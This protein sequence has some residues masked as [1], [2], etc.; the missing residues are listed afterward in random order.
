MRIQDA[1]SCPVGLENL[2]FSYSL[3]ELKRHGEFLQALVNPINGFVILDLHNLFCQA[4]NFNIP[5][6]KLIDAFPLE[7]V[8][9]VHIS[10]GSW[11]SSDYFPDRR[12]RRDTHDDS[13]PQEVFSLLEQ[14]IP[15][16]PEL[17][18]VVLEQLGSGLRTETSKLSFQ[19]DFLHMEKIVRKHESMI[20]VKNEFKPSLISLPKSPVVDSVLNQQQTELTQILE[21]AMDYT[22]AFERLKESSLHKT[23][24]KIEEWKPYMLE[25]AIAI[26]QKWKGGFK[27]NKNT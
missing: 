24:W 23:E 20:P 21:T 9:E 19:K 17:L 5:A 10:G 12:I 18:F 27:V 6:D 11:E 13:V 16:C 22:E 4:M 2:A 14:I 15:K 7:K 1:C 25:T 8:R 26:A 3:E